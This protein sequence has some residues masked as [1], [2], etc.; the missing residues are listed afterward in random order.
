MDSSAIRVFDKRSQTFVSVTYISAGRTLHT[1]PPLAGAGGGKTHCFKFYI[2]NFDFFKPH[3]THKMNIRNTQ[4]HNTLNLV[5]FYLLTFIFY[6]FIP[7]KGIRQEVTDLCLGNLYVCRQDI[8]VYIPRWRG[9]G[10]EKT[11]LL[12]T[13]NFSL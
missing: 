13:L 3:K 2:L 9:Q 4:K 10:V 12:Y 7:H 6:L 1:Y 11:T 8:P 5:N